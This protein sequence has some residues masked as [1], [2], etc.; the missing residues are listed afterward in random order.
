MALSLDCAC[1]ARF[2]V[3]DTLAG[4]DVSCPECQ[5]SVK[6]PALRGPTVR[7]SD[8]ALASTV[9]TLVGAFTLIGPVIAIVLGVLALIRIRRNR[10]RIGGAGFAVFGI[11][12]GTGFTVLLLFAFSSNE[13]FGLG[14]KLRHKMLGDRVDTTGELYHKDDNGFSITRPSRDWGVSTV[15]LLGDPFVHALQGQ[16]ANERPANYLLVSLN[17]I[18]YVDVRS[19]VR[20]VQNIDALLDEAV[21]VVTPTRKGDPGDFPRTRDESDLSR[22]VE[23]KPGVSSRRLDAPDGIEAREKE[24]TVRFSRQQWKMLV[25]VYYNGT[26]LFVVRAYGPEKH[27]KHG[28]ADVKK[29]LDSFTIEGP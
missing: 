15:D 7:T 26:R 16:A 19:E 18:L 17:R 6:A 11:V 12:G 2:E 3:E 29:L 24:V 28:E 1:G 13:L 25:R 14:A 23:V 8:L 22:I 5:Q 20:P 10:D 4:Q 21:D 9:I 27:M